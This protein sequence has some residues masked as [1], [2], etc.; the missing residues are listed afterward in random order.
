MQPESRKRKKIYTLVEREMDLI[1]IVSAKIGEDI[2]GNLKF[3]DNIPKHILFEYMIWHAACFLYFME[4]FVSHR[5]SLSVIQIIEFFFTEKGLIV[6]LALVIVNL[7]MSLLQESPLHAT[8]C[9]L[10]GSDRR[11][12]ELVEKK[13]NVDDSQEGAQERGDEYSEGTVY[14]NAAASIG[15]DENSFYV[16][17]QFKYSI[18]RSKVTMQS[19]KTKPITLIFIGTIIS[20]IG[21]AFFV[22]TLPTVESLSVDRLIAEIPRLLMLL[23]IQVLAGFFLKQY[24]SSTEDFRYYEMSLK[25]RENQFLTYLVA[26]QIGDKSMNGKLIE[27]LLSPRDT[28]KLQNGETTITIETDKLA[29]NEFSEVTGKS[30]TFL[31]GIIKSAKEKKD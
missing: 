17:A 23:F 30:L 4:Y 10:R 16:R 19:A 28:M 24:R 12:L 22:A 27:D 18:E 1:N 25:H 26:D 8:Y 5:Y 3:F 21:M 31:E 2:I 13:V 29:I 15:M 20:V 14:R 7:T 9:A 11:R 6:T